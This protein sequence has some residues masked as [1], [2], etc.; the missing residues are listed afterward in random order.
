MATLTR[1]Q[2]KVRN[3]A[4]GFG[5]FAID[6]MTRLWRFL[7]LGSE[8]G[9]YY[10]SEKKLTLE[11]ATAIVRLVT[12]GR[13]V[14]VVTAAVKCSMEGRAAKQQPTMFV[15][16]VCARMGD[17]ATR[18]AVYDA[19]P[20]VARTP[21]ML[22]MYLG[23]SEA[24]TTT[25]GWGR[26]LRRAI[27]RIYN[28]PAK[29][30]AYSVTKYRNREGWTHRDV[31]RLAHCK[32]T[33]AAHQLVLQYAVKGV[34]PPLPMD[35]PPLREDGADVVGNASDTLV[36]LCDTHRYL[37]AVEEARLCTDEGRLVVLIKEYGLVREHIPSQHLNAIPIWTALLQ[38]M[39]LT[40]L[41]RNLGKM[42]TI[43]ALAPLSDMA[44]FVCT[45]LR[46]AG[47]LVKSRVHPFSVFLALSTYREG[48]GVQGNLTW[49]PVPEIVAALEFAFYASFKSVEPTGLRYVIAMDVS[50]S[51]DGGK[52][53]GSP[54]VTPRDAAAAMAMVTLRTEQRCYP[55]AFT[56]GIVPLEIDA[57]MSLQDVVYA[58]SR[59]PF[60]GTDCAQPM[61]FAMERRIKADVFIVYTDCEPWAGDISPA[62]ALQQYRRAMKIDAKSI[63]VAMTS[64]GFSLANPDDKG[65]L[66][67]AGFDTNA[68]SIMSEFALGRL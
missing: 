22:F 34:V 14:E 31:L 17:D 35:T 64:G 52:V 18:S 47:A 15:L 5:T 3:S 33:T 16:A 27:T 66:D 8:G 59:L 60:G 43:G 67:M 50:G 25:T 42:T 7:I 29:N 21:T 19:L 61:L 58:T 4:G 13:G 63:V 24:M 39:P 10:A 62:E 6:D 28:Q 48:H 38:T 51:M 53:L 65:M 41:L 36:A 37:T 20:R 49:S 54:Q 57:T 2:K 45:R 26:G 11:N 68:P 12:K 23:F 30:L 9:T 44:H 1:A 46:D 55:L 40:A 32:P 56:R